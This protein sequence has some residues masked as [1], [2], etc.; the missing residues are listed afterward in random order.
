M[1]IGTYQDFKIIE[2]QFYAGMTE[3]LEQ[4]TNFF[5]AQS[6]NAIRMVDVDRLGNFAEEMY[7]KQIG[8]LITRRDIASTDDVTDK[9]LESDSKIGPKLNRKIGPVANTVD[10]LK[11]IGSTQE[12][13]S[14]YLGQQ[15]AKA[16][17]VDWLNTAFLA[18]KT[19]IVQG[20]SGVY[21]D[22]TGESNTELSYNFMVDLLSLFGDKAGDIAAF[23]M[24]SVP[25]F[26][27]FKDGLSNY[28]I[29]RVAGSL[30]VNGVPA[31]MGRAVIVSDSP[32]L[33]D[34]TG[35]GTAP[36]VPSYF[37]LGLTEDAIVVEESEEDSMIG[38]W[39]TGK[40]NLIYRIQGEHA[41][42]VKVKGYSYSGET[43]NPDDTALGTGAN[44]AKKASDDKS[45]AGTIVETV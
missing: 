28:K 37:T 1:A 6:N 27:L 45:T 20:G 30:I 9:K 2:D 10:S 40:E 15:T 17:L 8:D 14:F 5:N 36:D 32:S 13:F 42:N 38:E 3:I 35:G 22:K 29:D 44:W 26:Q 18:G 41:Y 19:A 33:I 31:A 21:A 12:E 16:K 4:Q 34:P 24:H 25:F 23:G 43:V 7:F 39:V 11:K